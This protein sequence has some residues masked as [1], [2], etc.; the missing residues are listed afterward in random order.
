MRFADLL[1][2]SLSALGQQKTR[3]VLT[4]LGVVFGSFVLAACLSVRQGVRRIF[5][6]EARRDVHLRKVDVF[7]Q[8]RAREEDLPAEERE[9][10]GDMSEEKRQRLRQVVVERKLRSRPQGPATPLTRERL[11]A[12]AALEH[13]EAVTPQLQQFGWALLGPQSQAV[14]TYAVDPADAR[15]RDR[16]VA[17]GP[18]AAD[19]QRAAVVSEYLCYQLGFASDDDVRRLVG[20]TLRLEFRSEPQVAGLN[21]YLTKA[22]GNGPTRAE[23]LVLDKIKGRLPDSLEA[24]GLTAQ[25]QETLR[26]ALRG[27][28]R[29]AEVHAEDLVIAGVTRLPTEEERA[30]SRNWAFDEAD[31]LLPLRTGEDLFFRQTLSAELGADGAEVLVDR[32]ENVAEVSRRVAETGLRANAPVEYIERERFIYTLI[33]T[34]MACVAAVALLV[35]ALGIVNTMLMSVLERLREIGIFKAVG[36][37]DGHVQMIFLI[38]GALIG[39]AGGGLGLLLGWAGSYPG[40]AWVRAMVSRDLKVELKEPLFVFPP[41]LMA[42]VVLFAVAVT[43]LAALYPARRAARVTPLTA[44]RHE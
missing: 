34:A 32:D 25:E 19:D 42:G 5:E 10:R 18:F 1:R 13:V 43:T 44:L 33:F 36:A 22:D 21:L 41:W 31:V 37:G 35:A 8:W 4:T 26:H 30:R 15:Y 2:L 7:P 14:K 24:L 9:V 20:R 17:G 40:D 12:L 29:P 6:R 3:T 16:L 27:P 38:E 28:Q 11:R 23:T 39:L